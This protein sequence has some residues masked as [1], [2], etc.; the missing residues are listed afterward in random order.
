MV[1]VLMALYDLSEAQAAA[2]APV[3]TTVVIVGI[4]GALLGFLSVLDE[5]TGHTK[6]LKR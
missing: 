5:S 3:Y 1:D 2:Q 6:R 4:L